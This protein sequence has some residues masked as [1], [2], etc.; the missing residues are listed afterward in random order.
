MVKLSD[1][2]IGDFA[3]CVHRELLT[4]VRYPYNGS[5]CFSY[6]QYAITS[7]ELIGLTTN[8]FPDEGCLPMAV[9][10]ATV[11]D[12]ERD[13]GSL[14]IMVVN[15]SALNDNHFYGVNERSRFNGVIDP[16]RG[17]GKSIVEFN[18]FSRHALSSALI[19][20]L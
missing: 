5:R 8:A 3:K 13:Y 16:T 20:V 17:R 1:N 11:Y 7:S 9:A 2:L 19:Q 15:D 6:P 12:L 14:V 18:K 4:Y 10:N